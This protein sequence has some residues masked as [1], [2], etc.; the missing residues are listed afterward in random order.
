MARVSTPA[1]KAEHTKAEKAR[2]A[3]SAPLW[4]KHSTDQL[5]LFVFT[6]WQVIF[7]ETQDTALLGLQLGLAANWHIV[8][9]E[10]FANQDPFLLNRHWSGRR[11]PDCS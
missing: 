11:G 4:D 8:D 6:A 9:P 1:E 7:Q 5:Q 2:K 3:N 10:D